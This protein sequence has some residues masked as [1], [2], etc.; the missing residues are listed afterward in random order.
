[1]HPPA[2]KTFRPH[3]LTLSLLLL[4][5]ITTP[6]PAGDESIPL[7]DLPSLKGW[8]ENSFSGTTRYEVTTLDGL[9]ALM[10]S[11]DKS[12]SGLV[13]KKTIDLKQTPYL[14]WSWR[15][16]KVLQ[17]VD[18]H[19]KSGDDYAARIYV[20]ISG[21]LFFWRTRALNYVWSS[22]Q[23][24]GAVWPNAFTDN[25]TLVAVRNAGSPM[26]EWVTEKRNIRE[27]IKRYLNLDVDHVD[28]VAIMTD[29]DN[30]GQ[31][32]TAYYRDIVFTNH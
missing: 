1:M 6:A 21:G 32:A 19:S 12:A 3:L 22:N 26:N 23:D 2:T 10:A 7:L 31:T 18:E 20:V 24:I 14:N 8:E 9:P 17:N 29:T 15:I 16:S 28:A 13:F 4:C 25:A 30:S 27:D 5:T 11:S